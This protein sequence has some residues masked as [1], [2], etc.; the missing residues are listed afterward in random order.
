MAKPVEQRALIFSWIS[1]G[2][3][4]RE[5][6]RSIPKTPRAADTYRAARRNAF[7]RPNQEN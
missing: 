5:N 2:R 6:V 1:R 7:F 4:R 3:Q